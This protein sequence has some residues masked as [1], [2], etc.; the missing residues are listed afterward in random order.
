MQNQTLSLKWTVEHILIHAIASTNQG[1]QVWSE[2]RSKSLDLGLEQLDLA[3][4]GLLALKSVLLS[5]IHI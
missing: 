4:L 1:I 5:L 2:V 3:G